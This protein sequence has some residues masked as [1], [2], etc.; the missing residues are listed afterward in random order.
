MRYLYEINC[1]T[2]GGLET[3]YNEWVVSF[4]D[5]TGRVVERVASFMHEACAAGLRD[6]LQRAYEHGWHT[7]R[8]AKTR[9]ELVASLAYANASETPPS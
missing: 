1:R 8:S 7:G 5:E 4:Q 9:A 6:Q 2:V 3:C